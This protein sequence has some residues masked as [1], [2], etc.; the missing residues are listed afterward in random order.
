MSKKALW[1]QTG[2]FLLFIALFFVLNL[3]IPD[4][5]FSQQENRTLQ[6]A[7]SFS[8]KDLFSGKFTSDYETYVTD[9]FA[10]RDNWISL[11]AGCELLSGKDSNNG[12]YLCGDDTLIESF[13][14]PDQEDLDFNLDAIDALA[15]NS[16]VPV[17]F[18]LI[19]TAA[20]IWSDRLPENAPNDSQKALIDYAYSRSKA[21]TID[22]Y[23]ALYAHRDEEIY[24]HTDH[25]W[26]TLGAYYGYEA[27][28]DAFG[29]EPL[30]LS[31]YEA[32]LVSDSFYGTTYSSSGFT[33]VEP[34]CI[35][36]FVEQGD[37]RITNY[38]EGKAVEGS[39]YDE[40][41]LDKKDKYSYFYGGNTPLLQIQTENTDAP[42]LL[43]LRDSYMDSLSPYLMAHFS[44]IHIIDLR[45]YNTS[46]Q[47]YIQENDIDN[48][49]VCY[50]VKNFATDDKVF[51]AGF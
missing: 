36:T 24:Y 2:V 48:V 51:L 46:V 37:A 39:L 47:K 40:S 21:S 20:E 13:T 12:I 35:T 45:Y 38:P 49:L 29:M 50:S 10:F 5:D 6:T 27:I 25:H 28:L 34:D 30:P 31:A 1:I 22:I 19:P 7:P 15:E 8:F 17:Y 16:S 41:F 11:K 3:V 18:A 33:W 9:Q 26:T 42:S 44:Q 32:T 23:S 43:I 4:R 14:Y